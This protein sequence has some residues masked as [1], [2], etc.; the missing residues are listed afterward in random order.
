MYTLG[1][2]QGVRESIVWLNSALRPPQEAAFTGLSDLCPFS[3]KEAVEALERNGVYL[4][5]RLR[6]QMLT[7]LKAYSETAACFGDGKEEYSF[8]ISR[9]AVAEA[10]CQTPFITGR[11]LNARRSCAAL[12]RLMEDPAL[13]ALARGYLRCEPSI[14]AARMWWSFATPTTADQQ[15]ENGQAFHFDLDG[16]RSVAFFFYLTEVGLDSGP[17]VCVRGSHK[18]KLWRHLLSLHKS[19]RE[20]EIESAYPSKDILVLSGKEGEG[21]AEDT[22]CFHKGLAPRSRDRLLLQIRF[23]LRDYGTG[24]D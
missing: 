19:R 5:L 17:H 9:R 6:Q 14:V 1:R 2:F 7:A 20:E 12:T 3:I 23:A 18:R 24:R 16:Y 21:F 13:W 22:F 15:M 8:Q 10:Q 4:N 11:Y